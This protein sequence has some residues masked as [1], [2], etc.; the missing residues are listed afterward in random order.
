MKRIAVL[1][2]SLAVVFSVNAA[3]IPENTIQVTAR[4]IKDTKNM[5]ILILQ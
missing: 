2:A 4:T 5:G 3:E 1:L